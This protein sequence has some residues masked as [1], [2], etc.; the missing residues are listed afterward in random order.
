VQEQLAK[1]LQISVRELARAISYVYGL[2]FP[3]FINTWRI[4]Y[5]VDKRKLNET[6][7]AYSLE[8]LAESGGFGS[9]QGLHNAVNRLHGTTPALFFA[10][11]EKDT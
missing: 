3:D 11:K 4:E 6:W 10:T 8:L 1:R 7:Q 2:S 9:R 5:L